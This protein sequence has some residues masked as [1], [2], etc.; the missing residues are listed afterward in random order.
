MKKRKTTILGGALLLAALVIIF[1]Q[2]SK[3]ISRPDDGLQERDRIATNDSSASQNP[4]NAGAKQST[5]VTPAPPMPA[6]EASLSKDAILAT[7]HEA[8]VTYDP[9]EL[10]KI[11][12]FLDHSD[13]EVRR[14]AMDGMINLGDSSAGAMLREASKSARTPQEAVALDEAAAFMELPPSK[15]LQMRKKS[16]PPK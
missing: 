7:I 13:A 10:P 6:A 2:K 16:P 5:N 8:S 1:N 4:S 9:Q 11:R 14:A 15:S 12:I 3:P